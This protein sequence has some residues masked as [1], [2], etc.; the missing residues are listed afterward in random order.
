MIAPNEQA[1]NEAVRVFGFFVLP[2]VI[3]GGMPE[4]RLKGANSGGRKGGLASSRS[5][6]F[7]R[8]RSPVLR[9]VS[10]PQDADDT[11]WSEQMILV[12]RLRC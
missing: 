10:D 3:T 9:V 1:L 6:G 2:M 8:K 7:T 11:C 12:G 5:S 4:L